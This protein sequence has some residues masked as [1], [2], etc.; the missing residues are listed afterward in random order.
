MPKPNDLDFRAHVVTCLDCGAVW[1]S[2]S[3]V[4]DHPEV[5]IPPRLVNALRDLAERAEWPVENVLTA[6]LSAG[7]FVLEAG[8][9]ADKLAAVELRRALDGERPGEERL[10]GDP[11]RATPGVA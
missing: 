3:D 11:V 8:D 6:L 7:A 9:E 2:D 1:R 5:R 4:C 10:V